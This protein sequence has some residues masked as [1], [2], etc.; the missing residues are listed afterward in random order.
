MHRA[1]IE[2]Q[3]VAVVAVV[4]AAVLQRLL[5]LLLAMLLAMLLPL[6][7][8]RTI[9]VVRVVWFW[10]VQSHATFFDV[11]Q[12]VPGKTRRCCCWYCH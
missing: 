10:Q 1:T 12:F 8:E 11:V 6:L 4:A 9:C 5:P 3:V 2:A 7:V